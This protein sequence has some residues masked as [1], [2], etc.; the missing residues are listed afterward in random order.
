MPPGPPLGALT[1]EEGGPPAGPGR[2]RG[3]GPRTPRRLRHSRGLRR[4]AEEQRPGGG[5]SEVRPCRITFQPRSRLW[6]R[7]TER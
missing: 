2:R 5:R 7:R 1:A 4:V 6:A 3:V